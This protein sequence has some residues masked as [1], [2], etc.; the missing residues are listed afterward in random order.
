M[1]KGALTLIVCYLV[2]S[3]PFAY[4]VAKARAGIDIR[5]VGEGN[6]GARNVFHTVGPL[7]GVLVGVLDMGKGWLAWQVGRRLGAAEGA[8]LLGGFAVLLGH[9]FPFL[10]WNQ[11][12]KGVATLMGFL[13]GMLPLP[14]LT[15]ILIAAAAH[16][17]LRDANRTLVVVC[18]T[19]V[20]V[21]LAYDQSP[22]TSAYIV[23]LMLT[24]ALKKV[25]DRQHEQ[26]VWAESGW[27]DGAVPG[28]HKE[29]GRQ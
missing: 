26:Q 21:P 5:Q 27:S 10:R 24:M 4:L 16:L 12:G 29:G 11:G 7:W 15:A 6:A 17:L 3:V 14:T 19:V 8:V 18:L 1:S 28:F 22:W 20:L 25:L 9:D 23:G 2:G 13:L